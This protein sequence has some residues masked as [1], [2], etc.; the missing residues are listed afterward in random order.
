MTG[1]L[2]TCRVRLPGF[3]LIAA[4]GLAAIPARSLPRRK[5]VPLTHITAYVTDH[6]THKPIFQARLTLEFRDPQSRLGKT[7][8]YSAKTDVKGKYRFSFIP[9]EPVVLVVTAPNHQSYGKTFDITKRDQTLHA[10]LRR[11]QPLR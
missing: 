6:A 1:Q 5:D 3:C 9:M 11:P 7:I 4:I 2:E 8:S 10:S